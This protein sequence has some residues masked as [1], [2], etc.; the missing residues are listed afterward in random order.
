[1]PNLDLDFAVDWLRLMHSGPVVERLEPSSHLEVRVPSGLLTGV[2]LKQA[3]H[4]V[5]TLVIVFEM[6]GA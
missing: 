6:M 4:R 1:M 3:L 5:A 2:S